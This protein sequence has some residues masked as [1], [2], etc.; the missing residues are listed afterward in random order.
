MGTRKPRKFFSNISYN[1]IIPEENFPDYGIMVFSGNE[2]QFSSCVS[3]FNK[4]LYARRGVFTKLF[5]MFID[6]SYVCL[7]H[8][9]TLIV[10]KY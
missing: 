4:E 2:E 9:L 10:Y 8:N 1:K 5:H 6:I 7:K 3:F